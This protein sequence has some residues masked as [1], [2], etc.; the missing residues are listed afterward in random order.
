MMRRIA[1][2]AGASVLFVTAVSLFGGPALAHRDIEEQIAVIDKLIEARPDHADLYLRRGELNRIHRD[3]RAAEADYLMARKLDPEMAAVDFCLGR[4]NLEAGKPG[5]ARA[6]LDRY[7]AERPKDPTGRATRARAL[8]ELGQPL[9]AAE[10]YTRALA[11]QPENSPKPEYYL[12]RAR[13][14]VAAG[15]KHL[16]RA[17]AGLDEGLEKLGDPVTLQL[18]ATDLEIEAERYDA[19]LRRV[20]RIAAQSVR[21]EPWLMRK[22]SI[23]E[24][25]GRPG[26]ALEMYRTALEKIA[27]L[28]E[29]RKQNRAVK[30]LEAEARAGVERLSSERNEAND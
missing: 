13:A 24:A 30:R 15:P 12:E 2:A 20:D 19:A 26:K 1:I 14:L 21:Q 5:E 23:L 28:P 8:V 6:F 18:Y 16:D 3:W 27:A 7:L 10:D 11:L 9:A 4:M 17:I 25:A 29:S 22:G